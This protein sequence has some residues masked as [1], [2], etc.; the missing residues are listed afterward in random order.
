MTD[1]RFEDP[2]Y[3]SGFVDGVTD[4]QERIIELLDKHLGH[5]DWDDLIA[6]IKGEQK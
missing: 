1:P 3:S 2:L 4:E 6:L 5:M